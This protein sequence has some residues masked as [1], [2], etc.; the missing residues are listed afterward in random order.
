MFHI[1]DLRWMCMNLNLWFYDITWVNSWWHFN[2]NSSEMTWKSF[3]LLFLRNI[4]SAPADFR[5]HLVWP[6]M[7][8]MSLPV[9]R[10]C[11]TE[12]LHIQSHHDERHRCQS[13][14]IALLM[15]ICAFI[16]HFSSFPYILW[17]TPAVKNTYVGNNTR[18]HN[19]VGWFLIKGPWRPKV[20]APPESVTLPKCGHLFPGPLPF[21][22]NFT[23]RCSEISKML[24]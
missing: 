10:I 16:N 6:L 22:E 18:L 2:F 5:V 9:T 7:A 3:F 15:Q 8:P 14:Y 24:F 17:I 13:Q 4:P 23:Q 19:I 12:S 11:V 21:P 1:P 20:R